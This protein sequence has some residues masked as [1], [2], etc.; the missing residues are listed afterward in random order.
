MAVSIV[1]ALGLAARSLL[2]SGQDTDLAR[3]RSAI[4]HGEAAIE[5]TQTRRVREAAKGAPH[6]CSAELMVHGPDGD[7]RRLYRDIDPAAGPYGLALLPVPIGRFRAVAKLGDY[8]GRL[9]LVDGGGAVIDLPGPAHYLAYGRFLVVEHHSDAD[10]VTIYDLSARLLTFAADGAV[11]SSMLGMPVSEFRWLELGQTIYLAGRPLSLGLA[12]PTLRLDTRH[13]GLV[14]A[15]LT[16]DELARAT[17][18]HFSGVEEWQNCSCGGKL[19]NS[20]ATE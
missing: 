3:C 10:G 5:I 15:K 6:V 12:W 16:A 7:M 1:C 19:H 17:P 11:L 13:G 4:R 2:A 8:D 14:P 18:V 20:G 9:L